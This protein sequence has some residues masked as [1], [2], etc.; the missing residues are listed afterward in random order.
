[1]VDAHTEKL[2]A[3]ARDLTLSDVPPQVLTKVKL[4]TLDLLGAALVGAELSW[5]YPVR[6]YCLKYGR[7]ERSTLIGSGGER[8]DAEFAAL[9]NATAGHACELDDYHDG[10][11]HPGVVAVTSTLA[12]A[13]EQ[14]ASGADYLLA[15]I[16]AMEI[17]SRVTEAATP[18]YLIDRGFHATS[19]FGVFGA[20]A[21]AAR[22]GKLELSQFVCA[23]S[24]AAS[25]ASGLSEYTQTGGEIKRAHAGFAA[26]GGIRAARLARLGLTA[27]RTALEGNKGFLQAYSAHPKPDLL[28][29]EIGRDWAL[30]RC[31]V[32]PYSCCGAMF[33]H[34][35]ALRSILREYPMSPEEV[36]EIW[37]GIDRLSSAVNNTIRPEPKDMTGAQFSLHFTLAMTVAKRRNDFATYLEASKAG[38]KDP[39]I[40]DL[41]RRVRVEF[42]PEC[43]EAYP[44]WLAKVVV[45]T[46]DGRTLK[47]RAFGQREVPPGEVEAKF[48][49]LALQTISSGTVDSL[50]ERVQ[51]LERLNSMA[52][53]TALLR[54]TNEDNDIEREERRR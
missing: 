30:M 54:T 8:I 48:R 14:E 15:S 38:F 23:L 17:I 32:K 16:V 19:I 7:A 31:R 9:G 11:G 5:I 26:A 18:S 36:K 29:Q 10:T 49:G 3:F 33:H 25:H 51:N 43:E 42:D 21:G 20:A 27:P 46:H 22:L 45:T 12:M 53:V 50:I 35:D 44:R 13:E 6:A 1:M 52:E 24:I 37:V 47:G 34:I 2:S 28:T 40:L 41:S 39:A 4:H